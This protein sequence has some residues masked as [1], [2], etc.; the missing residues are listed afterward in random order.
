MK[1]AATITSFHQC[2]RT[3]GNTPHVG[4]AAL[5]GSPNVYI[6][7]QPVLRKDDPLFCNAPDQPK[8][9]GGSSVVF[10]NGQPIARVGDLTSH[11]SKLEG[12]STIV[13]IGG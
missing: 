9:T 13:L 8:V 11:Q 4:G 3:T 2:K 5:K 1:P 12:G 7:G 6:Q 10:V